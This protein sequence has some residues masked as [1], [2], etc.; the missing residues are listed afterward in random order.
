MALKLTEL[1]RLCVHRRITIDNRSCYSEKTG[2]NYP[3]LE[4]ELWNWERGLCDVIH[5]LFRLDPDVIHTRVGHRRGTR[6]A[7]QA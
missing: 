7:R 4:P 2:S 1:L 6:L 3:D 5:I